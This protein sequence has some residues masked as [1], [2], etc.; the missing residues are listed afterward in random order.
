MDLERFFSAVI[1]ILVIG[2]LFRIYLHYISKKRVNIKPPDR[3][4]TPKDKSC[5]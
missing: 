3:K 4:K 1:T 5:R 2:V